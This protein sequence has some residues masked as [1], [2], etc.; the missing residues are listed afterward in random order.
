[1]STTFAEQPEDG[2]GTYYPQPSPTATGG[3]NDGVGVATAVQTTETYSSRDWGSLWF[4]LIWILGVCLLIT[5]IVVWRL[6]ANKTN[7]K[8]CLH[9]SD[10]TTSR[11]Q[12]DEKQNNDNDD[13]EQSSPAATVNPAVSVSI[14]GYQRV[15]VAIS[16]FAGLT[17]V[18]LSIYA[19][20]TCEFVG[21][22]YDSLSNVNGWST[23]GYYNNL[24]GVLYY[25]R[26]LGLWSV[27]MSPGDGNDPSC[28]RDSFFT[29]EGELPP[30]TAVKVARGSAIL[31]SVVGGF[32]WFVLIFVS[33]NLKKVEHDDGPTRKTLSSLQGSPSMKLGLSVTFVV[34]A[35]VQ[36]LT[37]VFFA[38]R[39]CTEFTCNWEYGAIGS[40]TAVWFWIQACISLQV[41]M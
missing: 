11:N 37:L 13:I 2:T 36:L 32:A 34:T 30:D 7:N 5:T 19:Q 6:M 10:T 26:S 40:I 12:V 4:F 14:V 23:N 39:Y 41:A 25:V 8:K 33:M 17:A 18:V 31:A 27:S 24:A 9:Q 1:M 29:D 22:D 28:A 20:T 21:F 35:C 3:S 38:N 15:L 16:I